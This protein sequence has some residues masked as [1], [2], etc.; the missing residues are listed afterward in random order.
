MEKEKIFIEAQY[1][2]GDFNIASDI[3]D[4]LNLPET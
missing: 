4:T 1:K 3:F 2:K